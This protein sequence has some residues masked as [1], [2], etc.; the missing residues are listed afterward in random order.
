M[1][2]EDMIQLAALGAIA[3][4]AWEKFKPAA[5]SSSTP[6]NQTNANNTR[7]IAL[8]PTPTLDLSFGVNDPTSGWDDSGTSNMPMPG[9]VAS[10]TMPFSDT[11][12]SGLLEAL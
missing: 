2:I 11:I 7:T 12:A 3:F 5:T 1:K 10:Y 6:S 8:R 4:L 9:Q